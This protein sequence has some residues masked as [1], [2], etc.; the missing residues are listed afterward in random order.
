[1]GKF[2]VWNLL[3]LCNAQDTIV[4]TFDRK[5]NLLETLQLIKE[6]EVNYP[7]NHFDDEGNIIGVRCGEMVL[8]NKNL[9]WARSYFVSNLIIPDCM[10]MFEIKA[11]LD[12][13]SDFEYETLVTEEI[14]HI[15]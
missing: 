11:I 10:E 1:M 14:L 2:V 9:E 13:I 6:A 4:L 12:M 3:I 15:R 5:E 7:Q 8:S